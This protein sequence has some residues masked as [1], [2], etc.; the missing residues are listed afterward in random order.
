MPFSY[1]RHT[2]RHRAVNH[3]VSSPNFFCPFVK[4]FGFRIFISQGIPQEGILAGIYFLFVID[5]KKVLRLDINTSNELIRTQ[6][7]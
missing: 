4:F 3:H 1:F 5:C 6:H 7:T 2:H